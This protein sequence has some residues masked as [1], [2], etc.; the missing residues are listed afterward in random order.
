MRLFKTKAFERFARAAGLRDVA[1]C[2]AIAAVERGLI[3]ADLGGGVLKQRMARPGQG[4][5]GGSRVMILYK[6]TSLAFFVHGFAKSERTNVKPDELAALKELAA[7]MLAYDER[8]L[9][10]AVASGTLIEVISK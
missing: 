9:A 1:L 7:V 6:R 3:G 10:T 4:K 5:S 2:E 8:A